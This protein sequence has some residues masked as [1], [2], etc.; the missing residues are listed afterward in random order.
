MLVAVL[1]IVGFVPIMTS[2]GQAEAQGCPGSVWF[3]PSTQVRVTLG[4]Q[5]NLRQYASTN[6]PVLSQIA[7]LGQLTIVSGPICA[8][9]YSWYSVYVNATSQYGWMAEGDWLQDYLELVSNQVSFD[10]SNTGCM[11]QPANLKIGEYAQVTPGTPNNFRLYPTIGY[12][13][14]IGQIP[15]G[16][17]V[18]VLGGPYC[19]LGYWW[20]EVNYQGQSGWTVDGPPNGATSGLY[21]LTPTWAGYYQANL[22][23]STQP[24]NLY[25]GQTARVT[26]GLPNNVRSRPALAGDQVGL[27]YQYEWFGITGGPICYDG[28]WWWQIRRDDGLSGWTAQGNWSN[29]WIEPVSIVRG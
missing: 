4:G 2:T 8:N 9:G 19:N 21:W 5:N 29:Y 23:C 10:L 7:E 13:N 6:A 20:W 17:A 27:M 18:L 12:N 11:L 3:A 1:V 16:V 28:Y 14:L 24:L 15:G 22:N 25:I 26:T